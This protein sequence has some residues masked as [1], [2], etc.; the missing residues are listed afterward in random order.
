MPFEFPLAII[1]GSG[2]I[3]KLDVF[4]TDANPTATGRAST[5]FRR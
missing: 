4:M 1:G 2:S 3:E 5:E